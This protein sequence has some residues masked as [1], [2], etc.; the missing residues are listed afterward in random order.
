MFV[1]CAAPLQA[2]I[3]INEILASNASTNEDTSTGEYSDWVELYNPTGN[4]VS[5]RGY[6]L[7]DNLSDATKWKFPDTAVIA[8]GGYL[9]VWCDGTGEGLHT[10]FK[11]SADGE[12]VGLVSPDGVFVDSF[13]F[14]SQFVDASF[15]RPADTPTLLRFFA[16]PTPAAPNN[17]TSYTGCANQPVILTKGG[18]FDSPVTVSI[19]QDLGGTVHYTLDG[20][21]PSATSTVYTG[22]IKIS[23]TT[24]VRARIIADNL[25]PGK[26]MTE[27]YFINEGFGKYQL[28]VVS[29]A[30]APDNFWDSKKGIYAQSY[31]PE[32]EVP[33][34][35][36][37]FENNGSD[38]SAF[39][40]A[41]G[42]KINGLY[43]WKL[44][45]KML[46]VY[47]RKQYGEGKLDYQ[48]FFD[49]KRSTFDN[50]ALRA[51]G[52]DWSNTLFRDGLMQQACRHGGTDLELMAF[53]PSM[54]YLNGKFLGI[55]NIREKVD[56]DYI[57]SNFG[58][59][60]GTFDMIESGENIETGNLAAWDSLS[61]LLSADLSQQSNFDTVA[62]SLDVYNFN[63]YIAAELYCK[64]TSIEHNVM[65]WKPRGYGKWRYILMDTDRGFF[66]YGN[67]TIQ[68]FKNIDTWPLAKLMKNEAY[69][70][71]LFQHVADRLFT[72]FNPLTIIPQINT[73]QQDIT[74]AM[75]LHIAR[76]SGTT[77]S[78]GNAM[79][80][81]SYWNNEVEEL[82]TFAAGRPEV[83]LQ[84]LAY[85][86]C[87][88]P[89]LL[90]LSSSPANACQW[91]FNGMK[92]EQSSWFGRYPTKMPITLTAEKRAGYL[93]K[94][95]REN[96]YETL[97]PKSSSWSFLDDGS[98]QGSA[99]RSPSFD[100]SGWKTG[101]AP[102]GYSSSDLNTEVSYG[103]NSSS[104]HIT[105][106]FRKHFTVDAPLSGII[107]L[108]LSLR[109][110]DGARIYL[111]GKQIVNHD[112]P[113]SELTYNTG[114][115]YICESLGETSYS[116][117]DV[118][119]ADLLA[120][121]N[122]IAV[123]VH[124][125]NGKS[126]DLAFDLQLSAEETTGTNELFS[127]NATCT[128]AL[129]AD[130]SLT[131]VYEQTGENLVPDSITTDMVFYK[132]RSPYIVPNDVT[133]K[134]GCTLTI[135]PGV[136]V[137]MN[138]GTHFLV[139]GAIDARGLPTD[140]IL[141]RLNP[142]C[143][144]DDNWGALCFINT[145]D[146]TFFSYAELRSASNGPRAYNCVAALSA[147]RATLCLDHLKLDRNAGNPIAARYSDITLSNSYLHS[148]IT[149][150]LV[151]VKYGKG[152]ILNCRF[153]G[154]RMPDTD[155]IDLDGVTGS[156]V[157]NVCITDME[158][159]NSDAVDIGE[160]TTETVI[161]SLMA[162]SVTDKGVS[163]GQR[164]HVS[165]TNSTFIKMN[166]GLG[167]KDSSSVN[168]TSCT[169]YGV[170]TPVSCF[171]KIYGRAGGNALV[172][173]S[174][175]S[176]SYT[177]TT[178]CDGKSTLLISESISDNDTLP[179]NCGNL[180]GNPGFT[181]PAL[182]DLRLK[183][184]FTPA[185]GSGFMP[186]SPQPEPVI[187][188]IYYLTAA[189]DGRTEYL[190]LYNPREEVMD[191]SGYTLSKAMEF[192]FPQGTTIPSHGSL[193]VT[194]DKTYMP[195]DVEASIFDWT[196]G[197]LANE[198]EAVCL[199]DSFGI[200]VDQVAWLP[201][202]PWPAAIANGDTM[203]LTLFDYT[204]DNHL[205]EYWQTAAYPTAIRNVTDN[206]RYFSLDANGTI[207]LHLP[208]AAA[209]TMKVVTANG[210]TLFSGN[211]TDGQ[212][213][214][215]PYSDRQT[216]I[217]SVCG[218]TEK[219]MLHP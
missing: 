129:Q 140:S 45:Q 204:A 192:V 132:A 144:A 164:S 76:W 169:F 35:I 205:P 119:T 66:G 33:V 159:S 215:L 79:P 104:K 93:F 210:M 134:A 195:S 107:S 170:A 13:S 208:D 64:N 27:T 168:I 87:S 29:I 31:K 56:D 60:G 7:T 179:A 152:K 118:P 22:P 138:P 115:L 125:L 68:Y 123:E 148:D 154:N 42:I 167:V 82:R 81:F 116:Y 175:L 124:Q 111:N 14:S 176:N 121:D 182:Y 78:Y 18:F 98:D 147:F 51:S 19:T 37:L 177:A 50:F 141:F 11:L 197:N 38:R 99:W 9:L 126:S 88:A 203:S 166:L 209:H 103:S 63:E 117:F 156:T 139:H 77:S 151:N 219:T 184:A 59:K 71:Q 95:W 62:K 32:W 145:T 70:A 143:P 102:L 206:A 67:N 183:K 84:E 91:L 160:G 207:T 48:L 53:R 1:L 211:V 101:T 213:V 137:W 8:A 150:D 34:N 24:I 180:H 3:R 173:R 110:D 10:T 165:V 41:A 149:G 97:I 216:L 36:E 127:T 30:T 23:K 20:T 135:E 92:A 54:V 186:Y 191:I 185:L 83:V 21:E 153:K 73:H 52:N 155:A 39:N 72:T 193:Y 5:L 190:R 181:A 80:S 171:E 163:V 12:E 112:L 217:I 89:A 58:L 200:A 28:P 43:S 199:N 69:T 201:H 61:V 90:S 74:A 113:V 96:K 187:A 4:E 172:T 85:F 161:D 202:A 131:A 158:G 94:G 130:R 40:E 44:P 100:D 26:T 120:G 189:G 75:P 174:I 146:T 218:K 109:A 15:G 57:S 108:K 49:H 114:A 17:T 16:K 105:T 157:R 194:K 133:I 162:F 214:S 55:H 65:A 212:S 142:A 86:G 47:F 198:G 188:E 122:V 25:L 178:S 6:F 2:Q 196:K 128:F 106:Y 46:G 136:E